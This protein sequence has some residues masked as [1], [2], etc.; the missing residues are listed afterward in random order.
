MT[1]SVG[2]EG[3]DRQASKR[4]WSLPLPVQPWATVGRAELVRDLDELLRRCSGRDRAE[5]SGYLFSYMAFAAMALSQELIRRT[6]RAGRRTS[7][8]DH[9]ERLAPSASILAS[10]PVVLLADVAAAR[11]RHR[12]LELVLEPLHADRRV[13]AAR[14]REYDLFLGAVHGFR[15]HGSSFQMDAMRTSPSKGMRMSVVFR[16][17]ALHPRRRAAWRDSRGA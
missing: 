10:R 4:T 3:L 14:V 12:R 13:E 5:S 17:P 9:A 2:V 1:L 11:R 8:A 16:K 15:A 7:Q 6:R